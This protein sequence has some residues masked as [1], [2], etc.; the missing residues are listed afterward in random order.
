M[1]LV[2]V[3]FGAG[4]VAAQER[5]VASRDFP[6]GHWAYEG[7]N[8]LVERGYLTNLNPLVQPYRRIEI[9][10]GLADLD[11][12]TLPHAEGHWVRLLRAELG[13]ELGRTLDRTSAEWGWQATVQ[14]RAQVSGH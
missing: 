10:H 12:D 5:Q 14:V 8:H 3:L 13:R 9:A 6:V 7:V 2:I 1:A 11:P 4:D